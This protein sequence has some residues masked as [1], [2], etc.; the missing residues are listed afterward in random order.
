MS[1][2]LIAI[3]IVTFI[4]VIAWVVFEIYHSSSSIYVSQ[5]ILDL[6]Q[7]IEPTLDL[8][9]LKQLKRLNNN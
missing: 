7:P 5:E 9:Y 3:L 6:A 8:E 1:K 2:D 4:T